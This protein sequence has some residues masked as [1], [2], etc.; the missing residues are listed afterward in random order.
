[1][2][3]ATSIMKAEEAWTLGITGENTVIA[4]IDTGVD[5]G[6]LGLGYWDSVA[7]D[8]TGYTSAFDADAMCLAYT[9]ITLTAYENAM[10]VFIPTTDLDPLIY[11]LGQ[12][13]KLSELLGTTWFTDMEVTGIL[14]EGQECHWGIMFQWLCVRKLPTSGKSWV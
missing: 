12:A 6:A 7:R 10:G 13:Y 1:M 5:Y 11:V 8:T 14:T 2:R 4:I 9:N 3:E